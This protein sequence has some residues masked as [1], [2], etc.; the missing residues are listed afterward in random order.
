MPKRGLPSADARCA[1]LSHKFIDDRHCDEDMVIAT[2]VSR[3]R[4]LARFSGVDNVYF[5]PTKSAHVMRYF[6]AR[7]WQ[8]ANFLTTRMWCLRRFIT[9]LQYAAGPS[10]RGG[11][12]PSVCHS[13]N[14]DK[15]KAP[16]EKS[17]IMTNRKSPTTLSMSLR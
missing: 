16:S 7:V 1:I 14:C 9:A 4:T 11:V 15:T 12:R 5:P 13:V 6:V 3:T 2:F 17:S 8:S 10:D